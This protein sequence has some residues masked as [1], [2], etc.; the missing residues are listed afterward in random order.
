MRF[1]DASGSPLSLPISTPPA[2]LGIAMN[3]GVVSQLD[4]SGT[5]QTVRGISNAIAV[6]TGVDLRNIA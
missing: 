2:Y 5:P 1:T 4:R 3:V 6:Q